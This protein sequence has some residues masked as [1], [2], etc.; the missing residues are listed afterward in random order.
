MFAG[1]I[2]AVSEAV[3]FSDEALADLRSFASAF[4]SRPAFSLSD[5]LAMDVSSGVNSRPVSG[6]VPAAGTGGTPALET[7]HA[8]R[9]SAALWDTK[10]LR[11]VQTP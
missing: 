1:A 7:I 6:L 4:G 2:G 11:E 9:E 10:S 8:K 5:K 3:S